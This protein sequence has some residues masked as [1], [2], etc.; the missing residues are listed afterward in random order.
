MKCLSFIAV[1]IALSQKFQY[2]LVCM[3]QMRYSSLHTVSTSK[4]SFSRSTAAMGIS[5]SPRPCVAPV[6]DHPLSWSYSYKARV[7]IPYVECGLS[8][9]FLCNPLSLPTAL[10]IPI[11]LPFYC[12]SS[13]C[14]PTNCALLL[15][16]DLYNVRILLNP[17]QCICAKSGL[18][19]VFKNL[20][21]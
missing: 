6:N 9:L 4:M 16:Q 12:L 19:M 1:I 20:S 18:C 5:P 10:S 15:Y 13:S 8:G 11:L 21:L 17:P 7:R 14:T 2:S 3:S